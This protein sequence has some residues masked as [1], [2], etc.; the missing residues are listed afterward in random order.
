MAIIQHHFQAHGRKKLVADIR[1]IGKDPFTLR[2]VTAA[3]GGSSKGARPIGLLKT[4][5]LNFYSPSNPPD[6]TSPF[7][8]RAERTPGMSSAP[9]EPDRFQV[10]LTKRWA[11]SIA[12]ATFF[13]PS[14]TLASIAFA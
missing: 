14:G 1:Q 10:L 9:S 13:I 4:Y 8:T 11:R 7:W 2:R 5:S 12:A 3:P 6:L